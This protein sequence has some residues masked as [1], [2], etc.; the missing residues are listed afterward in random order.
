MGN[1]K[2]SREVL[3]YAS[4]NK[5]PVISFKVNEKKMPLIRYKLIRNIQ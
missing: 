4:E 2:S 1:G 3:Q 5:I